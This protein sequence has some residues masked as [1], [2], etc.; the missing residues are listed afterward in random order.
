MLGLKG[1]C[2]L[3]GTGPILRLLTCQS[4]T[5]NKMEIIISRW[6]KEAGA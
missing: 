3:H 2:N 4:M 1:E 6:K 5:A